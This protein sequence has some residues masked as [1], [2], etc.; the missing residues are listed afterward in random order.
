MKGKKAIIADNPFSRNVAKIL[1]Y[2]E[3]GTENEL[4]TEARRIAE[5]IKNESPDKTIGFEIMVQWTLAS[6]EDPTKA[7]RFPGIDTITLFADTIGINYWELFIPE[8][9]IDLDR[10]PP[11]ARDIMLAI[12]RINSKQ[13]YIDIQNLIIATIEGEAE[14]IAELKTNIFGIMKK[15]KVDNNQ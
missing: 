10:L 3:D 5:K 12:S 4:R 2:K 11:E 7:R 14:R 1:K 13:L 9:Y 6:D 8:K 15:S